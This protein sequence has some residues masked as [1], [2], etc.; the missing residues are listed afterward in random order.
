[1][2]QVRAEV[3]EELE[4]L[5]DDELEE[6]DAEPLPTKHAAIEPT[7]EASDVDEELDSDVEH[8]RANLAL[9]SQIFAIDEE[10]ETP[11]SPEKSMLRHFEH[12][13]LKEIYATEE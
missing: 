4:D 2:E 7:S 11:A 9:V 13:Q 1:M 10:E 5:V 3:A 12:A 8:D 6:E